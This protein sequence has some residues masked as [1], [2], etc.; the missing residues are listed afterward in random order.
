MNKDAEMYVACHQKTI[1]QNVFLSNDGVLR[2]EMVVPYNSFETFGFK[3]A[4][5]EDSEMY[6]TCRQKTIFH[7]VFLINDGAI[8]G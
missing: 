5:N 8:H 1:F 7:N 2:G 4:M 3:N 6:V